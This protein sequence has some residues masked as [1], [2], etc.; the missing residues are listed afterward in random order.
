MCPVSG[1][2]TRTIP[3]LRFYFLYHDLDCIYFYIH[4]H[5]CWSTTMSFIYLCIFY[6]RFFFTFYFSWSW[7]TNIFNIR[8]SLN[9]FQ[10]VL[11]R[12]KPTVSWIIFLFLAQIKPAFLLGKSSAILTFLLISQF[13]LLP[14]SYGPVVP[15]CPGGLLPESAC[16]C[17]CFAIIQCSLAISLDCHVMMSKQRTFAS[18]SLCAAVKEKMWVAG[19]TVPADEIKGRRFHGT[20]PALNSSKEWV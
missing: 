20:G 16:L 9:S 4:Y 1:K 18:L 8:A 15:I 5:F 10:R 13:F 12:L 7:T 11:I 19:S 3:D 6:L 14:S 17:K 2:R